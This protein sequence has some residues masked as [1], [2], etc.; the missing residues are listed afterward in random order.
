MVYEK[1]GSNT[2]DEERNSGGNGKSRTLDGDLYTW[3]ILGG[4]SKPKSLVGVN[5]P[6]LLG[7]SHDMDYYMLKYRK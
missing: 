3:N 6:R 2:N 1:G 5:E 7:F 4:L